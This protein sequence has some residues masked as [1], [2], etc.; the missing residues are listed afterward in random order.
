MLITRTARAN[1]RAS[2][3]RN[4]GISR[5]ICSPMSVKTSP[6]IANVA[7]SHTTFARTRVPADCV[8]RGV[9]DATA[10]AA[11]TARTPEALICS[12]IRY[13]AKGIANVIVLKAMESVTRGRSFL[14]SQPIASPTASPP[15]L[16]AMKAPAAQASEN[17]PSAAACTAIR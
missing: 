1:P 6:P 16:M 14:N 5:P 11:T 2:R 7:V 10:P 8:R 15:A 9:R 12:A 13:A 4:C 17:E 3:P